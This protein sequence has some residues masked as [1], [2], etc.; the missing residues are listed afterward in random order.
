MLT[1]EIN[2]GCVWVSKYVDSVGQGKKKINKS[3]SSLVPDVDSQSLDSDE[4]EKIHS[5]DRELRFSKLDPSDPR[6]QVI[7]DEQM[8]T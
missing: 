8:F 7:N 2:W 3:M 1:V 4:Y 6:L 5:P